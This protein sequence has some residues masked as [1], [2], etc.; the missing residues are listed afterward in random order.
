[1]TSSYSDRY[2]HT[3]FIVAEK[4]CTNVTSLMHYNINNIFGKF[5]IFYLF[6]FN[7]CWTIFEIR[8]SI[9][10]I[11]ILYKQEEL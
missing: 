6:L 7:C 8:N 5:I 10:T 4:K 9:Y 1:M 2:I 3:Y 11:N